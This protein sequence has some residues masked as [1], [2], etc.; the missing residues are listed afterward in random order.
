MSEQETLLLE[1]IGKNL[2]SVKQKMQAAYLR[3]LTQA[4][5]PKLLAVTKYARPEWIEALYKSGQR[6]FG[7]SRPQQLAHR[8]EQ[9]TQNQKWEDAHWHLI[10]QLQRNKV[11][12]VLG[13]T[14]CIHSVDSFRLLER[15]E[16]LA[17]ERNF[18]VRLLLQVN[19]SQE[20]S[21]Q[22][23][24][25]EE[26][27]SEVGRLRSREF[28][29]ICGLMTMAPRTEDKTIIRAAF[30]G[31]RE[32]RDSLQRHIPETTSLEELSMGMSG[33]YEIAIEE[34]ATI[35]RIGSRLFQSCPSDPDN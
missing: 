9:Y 25:A 17:A 27:L 32:L 8:Y 29:S 24:Q 30:S 23:F 11:K 26:L 5:Q 21:K 19:I 3:R 22:G 20:Q 1:I 33:D 35:V 13:K 14:S 4:K 12:T 7:E 18:P 2:Q 6:D 10:G 28:L 16:H 34:G 31:L 15:I